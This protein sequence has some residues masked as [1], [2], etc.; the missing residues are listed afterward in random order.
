MCDEDF[1]HYTVA[2]RQRQA[3]KDE[4]SSVQQVGERLV[5]VPIEDL[6]S[7]QPEN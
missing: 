6:R 2:S 1:F 4:E 7:Q 3:E 5:R